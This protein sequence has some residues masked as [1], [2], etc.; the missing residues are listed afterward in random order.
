MSEADKKQSLF[1]VCHQRQ[2]EWLP[3]TALSADGLMDEAIAL[4]ISSIS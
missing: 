1:E 3:S 2:T 4:G